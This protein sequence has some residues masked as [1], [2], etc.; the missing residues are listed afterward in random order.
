[1]LERQSPNQSPEQNYEDGRMMMKRCKKQDNA[2]RILRKVRKI[3]VM[4]IWGEKKAI[5]PL[6]SRSKKASFLFCARKKKR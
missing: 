5:H 3:R 6:T 1:M 2:G 4:H